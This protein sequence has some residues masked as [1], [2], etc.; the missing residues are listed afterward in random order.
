MKVKVLSFPVQ[1]TI[2]IGLEKASAELKSAL[3][4]VASRFK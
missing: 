2:K 1:D 4:K 3:D